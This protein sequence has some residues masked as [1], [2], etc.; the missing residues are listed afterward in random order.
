MGGAAEAYGALDSKITS[1]SWMKAGALRVSTT[2]GPTHM[3]QA[4]FCWTGQWAAQ[5]PK[6]MP[7]C[8]DFPWLQYAVGEEMLIQV[9][10]EERM[11]QEQ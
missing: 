6:G 1:D 4:P 3:T 7:T 8:F 10:D 11:V 9:E 2:S 5:Q